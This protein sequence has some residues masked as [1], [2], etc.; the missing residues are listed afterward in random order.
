MAICES[1][2]FIFPLLADIYY[3]ITETGA[4]GNIKKQWILDR[5]VACAFSPAGV[6]SKKD[7]NAESIINIDNSITG[8][9]KTNLTQSGTSSLYSITNVIITNIRDSSGNLIYSES[10]GPRMGHSTI[11]ELATSSPIVGPFGEVEYYRVLLRRSENQA[12]DL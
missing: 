5:T 3:P 11:F 12:V 1:T 9:V 4:Y 8:R 10:A 7:V 6:K 2:D